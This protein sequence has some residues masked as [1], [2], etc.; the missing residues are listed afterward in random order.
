VALAATALAALA[1]IR[2]F[3]LAPLWGEAGAS[4]CPSSSP[5][6]VLCVCTSHMWF[7][8]LLRMSFD[9]RRCIDDT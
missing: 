5:G 7:L 2:S 1:L 6:P 9:G 3:A 8:H 4:W